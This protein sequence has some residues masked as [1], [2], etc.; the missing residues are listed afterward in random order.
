MR[1][2][3]PTPFAALAGCARRH[4]KKLV[5]AAGVLVVLLVA[6]P[7]A[8]GSDVYGNVGPASQLP[9]GGLV[10]RFPIT[11]Y[12]LDQYFPGV[13]ASLTGGID[14]SGV[15]PLIA[16]MLAQIIWLITAF[17]ARALIMLFAFAFSLDLVNGNGT[18]DSGALTPVSQAIHSIYAHTFGTPWL[19][20]AIVV[21]GC[22]AMW[23]AL[24]QRQ[25]TRTFSQLGV[26]VVY[27]VL[28]LG[29][30]MQPEAT[31]GPASKLSNQVS[32]AFLSLTSK[33]TLSGEQE[34]KQAA[35]DQLF[36]LMVAQP[37][38]VL[39]FG[40]IEHCVAT[41]VTSNPRS[42]AV[43]PLS[44]N[45]ALDARLAA[46]LETGTEVGAQGK[47]C[48]NNLHKYA[49]H[50]L[51]YPFQSPG[52]NAEYKAL[53]QG[54][55]ED[56][57]NTDPAK[58]EGSYPLGPVDEPAAEAMG[59]GGQYQRLLLTVVIMLGEDGAMLLLGALCLTVILAQILLLLLLAFAPVALVIGVIPGRGHEY[60]RA[61]LTRLAS[62][63]ARKAVYSLVLAIV[64]AV[65]RALADATS[66]LGWLLSFLL[67]TAFLWTVF[68]QR[69]KLTGDLLTATTGSGAR[70]ESGGGM[71]ALYYASWLAGI[72]GLH[73][74]NKPAPPR[75]GNTGRTNTNGAPRTPDNPSGHPSGSGPQPVSGTGSAT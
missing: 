42:V 60:F 62:Y 7:V 39:E 17:V 25:Y 12:Q 10:E 67:Q 26:S 74:S 69:N 23:K 4:R 15:P 51:A 30:V 16:Y 52:R 44:S 65:C 50:F 34:A 27:C 38:T 13:E 8:F 59:K 2:R 45:P 58:K 68:L 66:N 24:V 75:R 21:A 20:A 11:A 57:P 6:A 56:L 22:W 19:I 61:W 36:E 72:A 64:L 71:Q 48:V 1:T 54:K 43:R 55:D 73:P 63:L 33:G 28:A 3:V 14:V 46:E 32:T 41:P 37:W 70:G 40:G 35:S 47:V 53:Q 5:I 29:I 18:P 49:P 9:A 31:I